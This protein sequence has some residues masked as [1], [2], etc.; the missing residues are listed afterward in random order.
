MQ[1]RVR[2]NARARAAPLPARLRSVAR[3]PP[4]AA[5]RERTLTLDEYEDPKS[6]MMLMLLDAKRWRE[7]VTETPKLGSVEIWNLVN[8]TEDTHPIHLHLVRFQILD[9]Q[10]FDADEYRTSGTMNLVGKPVPPEPNEMGWKDTVR[11]APGMITRIIARFDGYAGRYVW[12]CH[13]L[14][15]AANEMMRPFEVI[16]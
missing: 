8:L 14:E 7:P 11:A 10:L 5:T 15:H 9:R 4:S 13:V 3:I 12:H 16:A 1:F 6:H 2:G